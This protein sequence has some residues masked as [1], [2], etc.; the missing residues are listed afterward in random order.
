M[1]NGTM[2]ERHQHTFLLYL[3]SG[4]SEPLVKACMLQVLEVWIQD[5]TSSGGAG[6]A[7][8]VL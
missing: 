7:R 2:C 6:V 5:Q 3:S 1:S 8:A 4:A